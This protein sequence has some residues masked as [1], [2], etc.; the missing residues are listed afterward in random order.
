MTDRWLFLLDVDGRL[1]SPEST[2]FS[3]EARVLEAAQ[4]AFR[5]GPP[6]P[7]PKTGSGGSSSEGDRPRA[8]LAERRRTVRMPAQIVLVH[9]DVT[10][11]EAVSRALAEQ[12]F[13]VMVFPDPIV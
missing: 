11:T 6:G 4:A 5:D 2:P 10:F 13:E 12:G 1:L 8:P 3:G 9:D 7:R